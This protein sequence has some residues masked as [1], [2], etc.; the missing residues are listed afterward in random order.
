[1]ESKLTFQLHYFSSFIVAFGTKTYLYHFPDKN[2]L[3][4]LFKKQ[5]KF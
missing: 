1:M 4:P 3:D 2:L 5:S